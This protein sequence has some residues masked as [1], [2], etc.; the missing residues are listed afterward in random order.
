MSYL[1]KFSTK[2]SPTDSGFIVTYS[3]GPYSGTVE[4]AKYNMTN[5]MMKGKP[6]Y[7]MVR[8]DMG[9]VIEGI[10]QKTPLSSEDF[11]SLN[12]EIRTHSRELID[13]L[14]G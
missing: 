14:L 11:N 4:Y 13:Q 2:I 5:L 8:A 3:D 12:M 10:H 1:E 6:V 7:L 9:D